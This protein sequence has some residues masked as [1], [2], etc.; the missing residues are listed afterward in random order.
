MDTTKTTKLSSLLQSRESTW[1]HR[2]SHFNAN[3][4]YTGIVMLIGYFLS[5]LMKQNNNNLWEPDTVFQENYGKNFFFNIWLCDTR[6]TSHL[7]CFNDMD[8]SVSQSK[9]IVDNHQCNRQNKRIKNGL[10]LWYETSF[11]SPTYLCPP[12]H[13]NMISHFGIFV[14]KI[15][16]KYKRK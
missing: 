5:S 6:F 2:W 1:H 11:I 3:Q 10:R 14:F 7:S 15:P 16:K 12:K 9:H 13:N 4:R 8:R